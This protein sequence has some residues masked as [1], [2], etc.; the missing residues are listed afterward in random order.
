M[1]FNHIGIPTTEAFDGE[2]SLPQLKLTCSD[3]QNNPYG[4]Q[5]CGTGRTPRTRSW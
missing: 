2:I 3:H 4:I 1:K 5:G